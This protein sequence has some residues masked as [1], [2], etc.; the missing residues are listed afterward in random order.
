MSWLKRFA[1]VLNWLASAVIALGL[2]GV[3]SFFMAPRLLGWQMVV[4]MSGSMEPTLPVGGVAFVVPANASSVKVNDILTFRLPDGLS[5]PATGKIIQ[6]THRV[7]EVVQQDGGL[8]FRTKGDANQQPDSFIVPAPNV[9]GTVQW[10]LPYVGEV[11][12][13]LRTRTGILL[14]MGI[15]GLLIVAGELRTIW[16]EVRTIRSKRKPAQE[17]EA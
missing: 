6:V 7:V 14:L 4:V 1:R 9:V 5:S 13:V 8:A 2:I 15:P 17:A 10:H 12:K 16:R 3:I 11:A